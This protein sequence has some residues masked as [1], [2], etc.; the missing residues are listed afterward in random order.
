MVVLSSASRVFSRRSRISL[1]PKLRAPTLVSS[2]TRPKIQPSVWQLLGNLVCYRCTA[3]PEL[4]LTANQF[5]GFPPGPR[6][7]GPRASPQRTHPPD[8]FSLRERC[9]ALPGCCRTCPLPD[10]SAFSHRQRASESPGCRSSPPCPVQS[11]YAR[12]FE[13]DSCF[14][15][16]FRRFASCRR[17]LVSTAHR[18]PSGCSEFLQARTLPSDFRRSR[19][20]SKSW[21]THRGR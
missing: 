20:F 12:H 19:D 17:P 11:G 10:L 13:R 1:R 6:L 5:N 3:A 18:W 16:E 8:E 21:A 14:R 15:C 7:S 2:F 9:P 4:G